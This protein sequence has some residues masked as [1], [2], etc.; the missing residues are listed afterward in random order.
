MNKPT[1]FP[2]PDGSVTVS[3]AGTSATMGPNG[4]SVSRG[5]TKVESAA[6]GTLNMS[7][8]EIRGID[9]HNVL[10]LVA[11]ELTEDQG[12]EK[13]YT[14]SL[15]TGAK[16]ILKNGGDGFSMEGKGGLSYRY[17]Q[18]AKRLILNSWEQKAKKDAEG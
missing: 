12:G 1:I 3:A 8:E 4:V 18:E 6:D 14:F 7:V 15:R 5:G 16:L 17:D 10:D 13:T 2:N 9:L 11:F